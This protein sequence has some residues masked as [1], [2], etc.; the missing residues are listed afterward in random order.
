MSAVHILRTMNLL[1]KG[2]DIAALPQLPAHH[3]REVAQAFM[4]AKTLMGMA[5]NSYESSDEDNLSRTSSVDDS[6]APFDGI[7]DEDSSAPIVLYDAADEGEWH[8]I[9]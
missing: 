1:G 5:T 7:E 8:N 2:N 9:F 6:S 3:Q 4:A